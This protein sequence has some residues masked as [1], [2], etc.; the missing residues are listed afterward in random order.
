MDW[1]IPVVAYICSS[2]DNYVTV[3]FSPV[4]RFHLNILLQG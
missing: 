4:I 2:D 3:L 1:I